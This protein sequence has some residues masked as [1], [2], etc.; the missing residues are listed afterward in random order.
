MSEAP[1]ITPQDARA[2]VADFVP[3]PNALTAMPDDQVVAYHGRLTGALTKHAP[4]VVPFGEKWRETLAGE[5]KDAINTL[6]RFTDPTALWKSYSEL[7]TKVSK[8]ELKAVAPF[9]KDGAPEQQN[10]WR[11]ANNIPEKPEAYDT[12]LGNGL[13]IGEEDKPFVDSYLQQAHAQNMPIDVVKSNL[14]W[15]FGQYMPEVEKARAEED[16]E[17]RGE[18]HNVLREKWGADYKRNI[19]VVKALVMQAPEKLRERLWGGRLADGRAIGDDPDMLQ[20]FAQMG[21]EMM[22][23]TALT[24]ITG[25]DSAQTIA[26]RITEIEKLMRTD[27]AAYNKNLALSGPDGE[28]QRLLE[29]RSRLQ[30][31]GKAA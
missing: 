14:A 16:V 24:G 2:F 13:V 28:Y 15:Y 11:K 29:A 4:K 21:L 22:P 9:P 26:T 19:E 1:Q 27:R 7:R 8:G 17:F 6:Q 12:N 25:A 3:D 31:R 30:E 10:E 18:A 23:Q 20:W 5:D